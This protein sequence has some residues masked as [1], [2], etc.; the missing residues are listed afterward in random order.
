MRVVEFPDQIDRNVSETVGFVP[1][2]GALHRGHLSLIE[3][4]KR[5]NDQVAVSIFVNP[6]QF[7][8]NEDFHRYPRPLEAD[9]ELCEKAGVDLVFHPSV[10]TMYVDHPTMLSVPEVGDRYEGAFRP[11]HFD[12][13]ATVVLMLLNILSPTTAYFGLKDL[14]QC[15][16]LAKMVGDLNVNVN[17][18]FL[19]T[20]REVDGLAMS[21]R[22]RYLSGQERAVAPIIFQQLSDLANLIKKG[23][24][25]A[26][27]LSNAKARFEQSG[28]VVD[29]VDYIDRTT[30]S[31][32]SKYGPNS[33]VIFAGKIGTTRLIDNVLILV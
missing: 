6:T 23:E 16:I 29:Y 5:E 32:I 14:Q 19:E 3:S 12:G 22:N 10:D 26:I 24:D 30:F 4:A 8:P 33:A 15:S 18:R 13:V 25:S 31:P 2:M 21:S 7:G 27:L 17:L 9:L 28:F 1:T 11:G 20:L